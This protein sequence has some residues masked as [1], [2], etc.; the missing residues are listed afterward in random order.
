MPRPVMDFARTAAAAPVD[1]PVE[2]GTIEIR[3]Q[4]T[5]T[6]TLK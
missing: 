6:V 5:L 4:V 3:A 2:P 1:T